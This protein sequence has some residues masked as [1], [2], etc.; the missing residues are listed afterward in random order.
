MPSTTTKLNK[1]A[2]CLEPRLRYLVEHQRDDESR[3]KECA[4]MEKTILNL[5]SLSVSIR[6]LPG[7]VMASQI[8]ISVKK[9]KW[10]ELGKTEIIKLNANPKF[11]QSKYFFQI[12]LL[13]FER[14]RE[15]ERERYIQC[16]CNKNNETFTL[17]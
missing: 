10:V 11:E 3:C 1:I 6:A 7:S 12:N 15:R 17:S 5:V 9:N 16:F 13:L 8:T 2:E 4:K 14:E